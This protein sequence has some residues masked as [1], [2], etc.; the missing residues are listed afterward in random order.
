[1][2][3][4]ALLVAAVAVVVGV[5][6]P[7]A[8]KEADSRPRVIDNGYPTSIATVTR[9]SLSET[10]QVEATLGFAGTYEL[11]GQTTGT[12]TW[13]PSAGLVIRQGQVLYRVDGEPVVLLYG[14][15]PAYRNLSPGETGVDV[16]E[17][18]ADLVTLRY[19]STSQIPADSTTF[20]SGTAAAVQKLQAVLG[21]AQT[22]SLTLGQ[23]AFEPSAVR[24]TAVSATL[25]GLT[26]V[27]QPLLAATSTTRQVT[28]DLD[29]DLQSQ[30]RVGD[31]VTITLPDNTTTAGVISSV[32][33]VATTPA[34]S[35]GSDAG[36]STATVTVEITPTEPAATGTWDQA[37]VG[38]AI[39]EVTVPDAL[40]VQIG[41][42]IALSS[43]GYAVEVV[44][45]DETHHLVDVSVGIIDGPGGLAQVSGSG[46]VAGQQVVIPGS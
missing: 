43:G 46:L 28:V 37:P 45:P 24:V 15:T 40:V 38:V 32:G 39:N 34:S 20:T 21:E 27:G 25:G 16:A 9:R 10:T 42:L 12:V 29:A 26:G 18:N 22:G 11:V 14:S 44:D 17:L 35:G 30:V 33:T 1:L 31:R 23:A 6:D 19:A 5:T 2:V 36:N 7:F 41:A 8:S 3:I 13:L 4:L